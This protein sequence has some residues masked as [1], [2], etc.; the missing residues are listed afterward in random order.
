MERGS[1]W[2]C[3]SEHEREMRASERGTSGGRRKEKELRLDFAQRARE[4]S[5]T[6]PSFPPRPARALV[7][8]QR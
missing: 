8:K 4:L 7:V 1:S 5:V 2:R 6:P 3:L